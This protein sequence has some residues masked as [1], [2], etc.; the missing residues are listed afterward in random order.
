MA[1]PLVAA[2]I[3]FALFWTA[4]FPGDRPIGESR[5]TGASIAVAERLSPIAPLLASRGL[6]PS[7]AEAPLQAP[8]AVPQSLSLSS[9][10]LTTLAGLLGAGEAAGVGDGAVGIADEAAMGS[11]APS[12]IRIDETIMELEVFL[13][14]SAGRPAQDSGLTAVAEEES[15]QGWADIIVVSVAPG[16]TLKAIATSFGTT[17]DAVA[18]LNGIESAAILSIG[19]QLHVPVASDGPLDTRSLSSS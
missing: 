5:S 10:D 3:G 19:Q 12:P 11:I 4:P 7:T 18:T 17:V 2:A 9:T 13:A 16:D 15:L 8:V 6:E 1:L 14:A